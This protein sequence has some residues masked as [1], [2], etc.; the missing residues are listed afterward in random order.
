[1][2]AAVDGQ[3]I[4]LRFRRHWRRL[5]WDRDVIGNVFV[6]SDDGQ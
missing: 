6:D 1:M 4:A 5:R 3:R 2:A